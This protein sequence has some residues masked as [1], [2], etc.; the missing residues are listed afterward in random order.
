MKGLDYTPIAKT[1]GYQPEDRSKWHLLA[2]DDDTAGSVGELQT[3]TTGKADYQPGGTGSAT[4]TDP[5]VQE[6]NLLD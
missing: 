2:A 4:K 5:L 1:E 3:N 6:V